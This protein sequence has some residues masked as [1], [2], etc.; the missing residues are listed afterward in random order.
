MTLYET[1]SLYVEQ[2]WPNAGLRVMD[3]VTKAPYWP[4][5]AFYDNMG[6]PY[7]NNALIAAQTVADSI[8][9][10]I[11]SVAQALTVRR[12]T[13]RQGATKKPDSLR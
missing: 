4:T 5:G 6:A 2:P 11:D 8:Q 7:H 3:K 1:R 10:E 12:L 13:V 9:A